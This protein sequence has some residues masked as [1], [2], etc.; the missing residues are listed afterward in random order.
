MRRK[1]A[2][3]LLRNNE[4]LELIEFDF[5]KSLSGKCLHEVEVC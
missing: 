5:E 3:S 2:N 1:K 4:I